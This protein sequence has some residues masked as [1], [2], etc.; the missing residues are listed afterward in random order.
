MVKLSSSMR[1]ERNH[2]AEPCG[3]RETSRRSSPGLFL[4]GCHRLRPG[5]AVAALLPR[6]RTVNCR[7]QGGGPA[8]TSVRPGFPGFGWVSRRGSNPPLGLV[9]LNGGSEAGM[10]YGRCR[11][12]FD[13]MVHASRGTTERRMLRTRWAGVYTRVKTRAEQFSLKCLSGVGGQCDFPIPSQWP[14]SSR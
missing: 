8:K 7:G 1:T 12:V 2:G 3:R 10:D 9:S 5:A 4:T 11:L 13:Q 6:S 14:A